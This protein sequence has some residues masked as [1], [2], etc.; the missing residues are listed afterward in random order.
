MDCGDSDCD[1]NPACTASTEVC[2][3]NLDNDS[4]GAIADLLGEAIKRIY[5]DESVS[6]LFEIH[7]GRTQ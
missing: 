5:G 7:Q 6:R 3:D 1:G 4:D 2:D